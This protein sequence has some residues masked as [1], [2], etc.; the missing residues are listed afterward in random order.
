MGKVINT[1][2]NLKDNFSNVL[3]R[4][5]ENTKKFTATLNQANSAADSIIG[6]FGKMT[7]DA[8]S[9]GGV[10][11]GA[12]IGLGIK[13]FTDYDSAVRQ[14][15]STTGASVEEFNQLKDVMKGVY[16]NNFGESWEDVGESVST[17]QKYL[18][19]TGEDIQ[20]VTE[21]AIM[22][23]DVF[24]SEVS[25]S[26]RSVDTLMKN[27]GIS[28]EESFNLIAQGYQ[29]NLD[30]S[31]ELIDSI[32]EYS[33]HFQKV[34]ID[35]ETMFAM[36]SAGAENGAWNVDKIGDAV[37]EF[38]IRAIDGSETTKEGFKE[39][40]LNVAQMEKKFGAGGESAREAFSQV[41][42]ALKGMDDPIKRNTAG[43]NLFGTM[44]ED[45]GPAVVTKLNDL[46]NGFDK[47]K[48]TIEEINGIKYSGF[49]NSMKGIGRQIQVAFMPIGEALVPSLNDLANWL[50]DKLPGAAQKFA[51]FIT[52]RIVPAIEFGKNRIDDTKKA[53]QFLK[54]N[55]DIIIPIISGVAAGFTAFVVV[56][57]AVKL[58]DAFKLAT[59]EV[60]LVQLL[61]KK[62]LLG[63]PF[64]WIA[65]A[66]GALVAAFVLAYKK[67]ETFRK[68]VNDLWEKLKEFGAGLKETVIAKIQELSEWFSTKIVPLLKE[69]GGNL[70]DLWNNVLQPVASYLLSVFGKAFVSTFE[71][72]KENVGDVI[73][74]L[75]TQIENILQIFNGVIEFLTG[76]FTRDCEKAWEGICDIFSGIAGSIKSIFKGALNVVIDVINGLISGVNGIATNVSDIPGLGWAKGIKIPLI[77][78]FAKGTNYFSGGMALVG[79]KGPEIVRLPGASKVITAEK[80]RNILTKNQQSVQIQVHIHGNFYGNEEAADQLGERVAKKVLATLANT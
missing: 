27:F 52:D 28:A 50:D 55:M 25:E 73:G 56:T 41:I 62:T 8:L 39:L 22:F 71:Y 34:G 44:W 78:T 20:K 51:Q 46:D 7:K 77:P 5:N 30:F 57:K 49:L 59:K 4:T 33:V 79:E 42:E 26:M 76:L 80:T 32:N 43:V 45:L 58:F 38:S 61:L 10:F 54:D 65:V 23:R 1:I 66:I 3:R 21:N 67:S 72:V 19:G 35:A 15:V 69:I 16:G 63:N 36:I 12:S 48:N 2:L 31:G 70:E 11:A 24:G 68:F 29:N 9:L 74:F 47:T 6:S 53:F 37:K 17:V 64:F 40:G 60:T 14:A 18:S 13:S 75:Q